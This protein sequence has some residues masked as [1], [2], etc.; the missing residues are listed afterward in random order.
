MDLEGRRNL[1]EF[2]MVVET[3]ATKNR[4]GSSPIL[5]DFMSIYNRFFQIEAPES[6]SFDNTIRNEIEERICNKNGTP[7]LNTF[8]RAKEAATAILET[9]NFQMFL[10]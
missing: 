1:I 5:E 9:V 2:L 6:L 3:L 10:N 4:T 8:E 7:P